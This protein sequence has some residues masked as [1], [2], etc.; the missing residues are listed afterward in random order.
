[1]RYIFIGI[2]PA[3]PLMLGLVHEKDRDA[4]FKNFVD[5]INASGKSLTAGDIGFH[6]VVQALDVGGASQLLYDMNFRD[7]VPGYGFQLKNLS[8]NAFF[9]CTARA[10]NFADSVGSFSRVAIC[11][12]MI[13][14]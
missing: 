1:M 6:Y 11:C 3:M 5:S 4:V 13:I 9:T 12:N 14:S 8:L 7:D 10:A 2:L